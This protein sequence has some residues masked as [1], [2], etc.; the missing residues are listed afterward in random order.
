MRKPR[1]STSMPVPRP[2]EGKRGEDGYLGYLLRQATHATT[3]RIERAL[4]DLAVT[5]PQFA[6]LTMVNAYPGCSSADLAR[7]VMQTPQT[8]S[9]VV[10]NIE[11]AGWAL[12]SPH[13]V[14]GRIRQLELTAAGKALLTICRE[15]VREIE[16]KIAAPLSPEEEAAVRKWLVSVALGA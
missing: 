14:H 8:L 1:P 9:V 6:V 15:R 11:R 5:A 16:A 7:L 10:A 4:A 2:G 12:R 3:I 13:P